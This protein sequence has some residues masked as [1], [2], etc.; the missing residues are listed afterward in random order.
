MLGLPQLLAPPRT[1][2]L[3][4]HFLQDCPDLCPDPSSCSK[5]LLSF[6]RVLPS[7]REIKTQPASSRNFR[8]IPMLNVQSSGRILDLPFAFLPGWL[9]LLPPDPYFTGLTRGDPPGMYS[10]D[11]G[12]ALYAAQSLPLVMFCVSLFIQILLYSQVGELGCGARAASSTPC[13]E[14]GALTGPT[15]KPGT[16]K[17]CALD[18]LEQFERGCTKRQSYMIL[19]SHTSFPFSD[20]QEQL[21]CCRMPG[22]FSEGNECRMPVLVAGKAHTPKQNSCCFEQSLEPTQPADPVECAQSSFLMDAEC[23]ANLRPKQIVVLDC[24]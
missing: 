1:L 5:P 8:A 14:K 2:F 6:S 16:L 3:K 15:W 22:I 13:R 21:Q 19:A 11:A 17:A 18:S 23:L 9:R 24:H 7:S 12:P 10:P 20:L 4:V